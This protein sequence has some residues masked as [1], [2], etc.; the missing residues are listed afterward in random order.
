MDYRY[1]KPTSFRTNSQVHRI[2]LD[3]GKPFARSFCTPLQIQE[4]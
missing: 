4:L 2:A 3:I 1:A